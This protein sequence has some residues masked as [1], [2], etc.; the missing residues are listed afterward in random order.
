[1]RLKFLVVAAVFAISF[2]GFNLPAANAQPGPPAVTWGDGFTFNPMMACRVW[3]GMTMLDKYASGKTDENGEQVADSDL[4]I[5]YPGGGVDFGMAISKGKVRGEAKISTKYAH[6]DDG[7]DET[8]FS[9]P[10]VGVIYDVSPD[11]LFWFGS[12]FDM[13]VANKG[14]CPPLASPADNGFRPYGTGGGGMGIGVGFK[15]AALLLLHQGYTKFP[16]GLTPNGADDT[17]YTVPRIIASYATNP[18]Y[19][20]GASIQYQTKKIDVPLYDDDNDATTP[21]VAYP[22][23]GASIVTIIAG[24]QADLNIGAITLHLHGYYH[25]NKSDVGGPPGE[26]SEQDLTDPTKIS[27]TTGYG[28]NVAFAYKMGSIEPAAGFAYKVNSNDNWTKDDPEQA[29][30]VRVKFDIAP[31]FNVQPGVIITDKM[32]GSS[33]Q[34]QG[35]KT[36]FGI[37]FEAM[38]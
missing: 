30:F 28:G 35:K 19:K 33:D 23:D 22:L 26:N 21:D 14:D 31:G 5:G 16:M 8:E 29:Y 6:K 36:E 2:L 9:S 10:G 32:K 18:P 20:I 12:G 4:Y 24:A 25:Q 1:M 7:P 15:G 38:L 13:F 17:D 11:L 37:F 3:T 27:N 34:K